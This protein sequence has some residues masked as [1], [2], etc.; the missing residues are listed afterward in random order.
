MSRRGDRTKVQGVQH[1]QRGN[2]PDRGTKQERAWRV[3][4]Y[5]RP[6]PAR[7]RFTT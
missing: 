3:F 4:E 5:K 6:T 1:A 7:P 2:D